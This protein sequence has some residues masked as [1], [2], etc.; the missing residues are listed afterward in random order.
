MLFCSVVTTNG[1]RSRFS[2]SANCTKFGSRIHKSLAQIDRGK[3]FSLMDGLLLFRLSMVLFELLDKFVGLRLCEDFLE[4][5]LVLKAVFLQN[6]KKN[7]FHS[8]LLKKPKQLK[9][10]AA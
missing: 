2:L 7:V 6:S 10:S 8:N 1:G 9:R 3:I 5:D 4:V